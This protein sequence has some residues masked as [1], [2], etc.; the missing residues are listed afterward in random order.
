MDVKEQIQRDN[1]KAGV[2]FIVILVIAA[3]LGGIIGFCMLFFQGGGIEEI[4]GAMQNSLIQIAPWVSLVVTVVLFAAAHGLYRQARKMYDGWNEE[5]MERRKWQ[6]TRH[7]TLPTRLRRDAA[8]CY[9]LSVQAAVCCG[10]LD[11][12]R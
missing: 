1:N 4:A 9:G 12:C 5:E 8:W 10:T 6:S 7:L 2:K 11:S 3:L